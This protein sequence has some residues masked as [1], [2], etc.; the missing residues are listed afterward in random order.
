MASRGRRVP[1]RLWTALLLRDRGCR[2]PGCRCRMNLVP[3]HLVHFVDGGRTEYWNLV[4]LCPVHHRGVH[5]TS[6]PFRQGF[7]SS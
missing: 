6:E 4:L 7:G 3:H 5:E 2:F 1:Q